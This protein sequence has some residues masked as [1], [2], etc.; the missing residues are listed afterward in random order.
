M[1]S[2]AKKKEIAAKVARYSGISEQYVLE[3]N[4]SVSFNQF[5]KE[6]LRDKGFTVGR[7]DSRYLGIDAKAA[8]ERPDY[9]AELTSWLHSFTPPIN[10]YLREELK[11]KTDLKYFMFGSV[12]PWGN[13]E[14]EL[15]VAEQL[16]QAMAINPYLKLLVQSGYYDGACDYFNAKYNMWQMDPSG[17][18]KDRM[19]WKGYRSGHMM[20]LRKEDLKK[21]ND[22]IREFIK[23][24]TPGAKVPAKF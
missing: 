13:Y 16:R 21:G 1:L 23:N 14:A 7:L 18:L 19:Y 12:H 2:D 11:F 24:S 5:W 6:L 3:N 8:G 4:L 20:Y 10:M 22:D 15:N 17:K 9:N